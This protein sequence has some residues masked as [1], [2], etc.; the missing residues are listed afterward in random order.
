MVKDM[1]KLSHNNHFLTHFVSPLVPH[2]NA[3]LDMCHTCQEGL[4]RKNQII[5]AVFTVLARLREGGLNAVPD[6]TIEV[7][8]FPWCSHGFPWLPMMALKTSER[9]LGDI[10]MLRIAEICWVFPNSLLDSF[11]LKFRS[12]LIIGT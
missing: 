7:D 1:S 4:R 2:D 3:T 10:D 5:A 11:D 9:M 8:G 12:L 6:Y